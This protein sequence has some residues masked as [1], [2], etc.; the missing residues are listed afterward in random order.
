[1]L[2]YL[3]RTRVP[4]VFPRASTGFPCHLKRRTTSGP[5]QLHGVFEGMFVTSRRVLLACITALLVALGAVAAPVAAQDRS[6]SPEAATGSRTGQI[7]TAKS[8]MISAANPLA[9]EAGLEILREGGSAA[10][11]AI[12]VQLVLNLVEPQ[13]SGLGGGAFILHWD[14]AGRVLKGYDGRE[15]APAAATPE[16]FLVE[17]RPRKFDEAVFGG[18]SV[19]VPGT[20]RVLEAVHKQHGRLPW[21]RLFAPAI[22]LATERLS[23]LGALAS[24]VA[25]GG[26]GRLRAGGAPILLRPDRQRLACRLPPQ[27]PP[28]RGDFARGCRGRGGRLLQGRDRPGDRRRRARGSQPPGRHH[29]SRSRRLRA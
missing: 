29:G 1:M 25:L 12:A 22:R 19:G 17:G 21:A 27:E 18:L 20:L 7:T 26:G 14:A 11:A 8:F 6:A 2:R 4:A 28:V 5:L 3:H 13:S 10:D 15:T 24:A 23:G 9:V 16:R